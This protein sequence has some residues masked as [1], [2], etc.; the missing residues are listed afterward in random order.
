MSRHMISFSVAMV[1]LSTACNQSKSTSFSGNKKQAKHEASS[2]DIF[3]TKNTDIEE[4]YA[5]E[6]EKILEM[7]R[8]DFYAKKIAEIRETVGDDT[9]EYDG[10]EYS[11]I[12]S[13]LE[14]MYEYMEDAG[15]FDGTTM[16]ETFEMLEID[17]DRMKTI[18]GAQ[19]LYKELG[20]DN[21]D[22][23][24]LEMPLDEDMALRNFEPFFVEA[25]ES[26]GAELRLLQVCGSHTQMKDA[27]TGQCRT[28][29]AQEF[30][31]GGLSGEQKR[32]Q[33]ITMNAAQS[34]RQQYV[35]EVGIA[36]QKDGFQWHAMTAG[37]M[38]NQF[39]AAGNMTEYNSWMKTQADFQTRLTS[40]NTNQA[41][42]TGLEA[43]YNSWESLRV[44]NLLQVQTPASQVDSSGGFA[45]PYY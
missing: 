19:E 2:K 38:A 39:K 20:E 24:H 42:A 22:W 7:P 16:G 10:Q 37:M 34:G 29:T 35:A 3:S 11:N 14:F 31:S 18:A 13:S 12:A 6:L 27:T 23:S 33:A 5:V 25:S 8:E 44:N 45:I 9:V 1:L 17:T 30:L 41:A 15:I 26:E 28:K 32:V 4:R 43:S 40:L 36:A 21:P